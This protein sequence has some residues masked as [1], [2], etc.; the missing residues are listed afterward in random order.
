MKWTVDGCLPVTPATLSWNAWVT[1][2]TMK[3]TSELAC[4]VGQ[5]AL[6][7]DRT[8]TNEALQKLCDFI[9]AR[10]S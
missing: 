9:N 5:A 8:R 6:A 4:E 1:A 3:D 2:C 7:H 10:F